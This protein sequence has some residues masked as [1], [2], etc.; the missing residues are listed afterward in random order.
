M[1]SKNDLP[2]VDD[3]RAVVESCIDRN[4]IRI[5]RLIPLLKAMGH[6]TRRKVVERVRQNVIATGDL[7]EMAVPGQQNHPIC[8]RRADQAEEPFTFM[9]EKC[10][11]FI[12]MTV[13]N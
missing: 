2:L 7:R 1:D 5:H 12:A 11:M 9:R 4:T 8:P 13:L 10:P 3:E 6:A